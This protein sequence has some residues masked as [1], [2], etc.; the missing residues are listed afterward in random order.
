MY[1]S[2]GSRYL[3]SEAWHVVNERYTYSLFSTFT[4]SVMFGDNDSKYEM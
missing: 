3:E 1:R 2:V 4:S